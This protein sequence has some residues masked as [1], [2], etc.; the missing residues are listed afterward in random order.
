MPF[1]PYFPLKSKSYRGTV[2]AIFRDF[3]VLKVSRE[4]GESD[5]VA[6][7]AGE[8]FC[9]YGVKVRHLD[10]RYLLRV[11]KQLLKY[12]KDFCI[13]TVKKCNIESPMTMTLTFKQ[14]SVLVT[15]T[16]TVI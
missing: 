12:A 10:L 11:G 6:L 5:V 14:K 15:V 9:C 7:L 1:E 3:A 4:G 16:I 8:D 2:V 13:Q